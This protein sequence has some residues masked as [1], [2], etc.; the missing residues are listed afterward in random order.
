MHTP[1]KNEVDLSNG[2]QVTRKTSHFYVF[3][4]T[5]IS[6]P[7]KSNQRIAPPLCTLKPSLQLIRQLVFKLS[8]RTDGRTDGQ[9][10]N[11]M[12]PATTYGGR[13]RKKK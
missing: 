7:H 5:L 9:P 12:P 10:G 3:Y 4:R 13:R 11:I 6:R 8:V 1:A 2:S